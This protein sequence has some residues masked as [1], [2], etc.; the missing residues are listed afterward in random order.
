[1]ADYKA[2]KLVTTELL[3]NADLEGIDNESDED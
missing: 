3:A 1:V 2:K